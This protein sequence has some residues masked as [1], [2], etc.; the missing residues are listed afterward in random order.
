M[1]PSALVTVAGL[2]AYASVTPYDPLPVYPPAGPEALREV[3]ELI[4]RLEGLP[5]FSPDAVQKAVAVKLAP[6]EPMPD[7]KS[8]TGK[9]PAGTFSDVFYREIRPVKEQPRWLVTVSIRRGIAIPFE[10]VDRKFIGRQLHVATAGS[11]ESVA[12]HTLDRPGGLLH[13][14]RGLSSGTLQEIILVRE[15]SPERT[16]SEHRLA[17][18][19]GQASELTALV[20]KI[21]ALPRFSLPSIEAIIG[22]PMAA[23]NSDTLE[24]RSWERRLAEGVVSGVRYREFKPRD[25]TPTWT[26]SLVLGKD[27]SLPRRFMD[28][29]LITTRAPYRVRVDSDSSGNLRELTFTREGLPD[30][31][32]GR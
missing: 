8:L 17:Q 22:R 14:R 11:Y 31:P 27:V 29:D 21:E 1:L 9:L 32:S 13:L 26:L 30:R 28:P 10:A 15:G 3:H 20:R 4:V 19:A 23:G 25:G 16:H 24:L 12:T 6:S 7:P 18:L 2:F 5:R